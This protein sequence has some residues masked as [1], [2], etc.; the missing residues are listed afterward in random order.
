MQFDGPATAVVFAADAG[1]RMQLAVALAS[2]NDHHQGPPRDVYILTT[3]LAA[4]DRAAIA[5]GFDH[6]TV[7]WRDVP[8]AWSDGLQMADY[9]PVTSAFRLMIGDVLPPS[10]KRAVYLDADTLIRRPI[11]HLF[12][13]DLGGCV[14][15]AVA[16]AGHPWL[17]TVHSL[18]WRLLGLDPSAPYFNA[19]VLAI[20]VA[21]WRGQGYGQRAIKL[22]RAHRFAYSD[23]CALNALANGDFARL[24]TA[25]NVQA[26]HFSPRDS[27][28]VHVAV[29]ELDRLAAIH[30]PTIVHFSN[31]GFRLTRPW[32]AGSDHPFAAEWLQT[33]RRTAFAAEVL[34]EAPVPARAAIAKRRVRRA[35]YMLARG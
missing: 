32:F 22:L 34:R 1:F 19:G 20:D 14:L 33:R 5:S 21:A 6:L 4:A 29:P 12:T 7:H 3:D 9:L 35:A 13:H 17:V 26:D 8:A 25:G 16:D 28:L 15:G 27:G 30:D 18:P 23:Q 31:G 2:L 11:D 24:A 10:V